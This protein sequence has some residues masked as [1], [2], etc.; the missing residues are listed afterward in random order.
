[1]KPAIL[2]LNLLRQVMD[3]A[4]QAGFV[5]RVVDGA[6]DHIRLEPAFDQVV[7]CALARRLDG[8]GFVG[9]LSQND[10]SLCRSIDVIGQFRQEV[11]CAQ[12]RER[13]LEQDAIRTVQSVQLQA[14]RAAIR[15]EEGVLTVGAPRQMIAILRSLPSVVM[16]DQDLQTSGTVDHGMYLASACACFRLS[17]DAVARYRIY[18]SQPVR[19]L[20]TSPGSPQK[21]I[22]S[23]CRR[24]HGE[25]WDVVRWAR[26][27][28]R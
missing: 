25:L 19:R 26:W 24:R 4:V 5:D 12:V 10:H 20:L 11:H 15:L 7:L 1:M 8:G 18:R 3:F 23:R 6:I 21:Q 17:L 2:C 16:Y 27:A 9:L 28:W 22:A 14:L 13:P